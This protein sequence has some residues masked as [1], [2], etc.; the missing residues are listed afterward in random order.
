MSYSDD[1]AEFMF[2]GRPTMTE[3]ARAE[4]GWLG[5]HVCESCGRPSQ[6]TQIT[7]GDGMTFFVCDECR[8]FDPK[9]IRVISTD[10]DREE[11]T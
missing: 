9:A 7:F 3:L 10:H 2:S 6:T 1:T 11:T 4:P 5:R 8:P